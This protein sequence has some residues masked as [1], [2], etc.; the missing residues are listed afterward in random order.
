MTRRS[1]ITD[2]YAVLG[3]HEGSSAAE[4]KR[5]YR[6][7][8]LR[9]HPDRDPS[10]NA[11]EVF[12]NVH[13]AYRV[14]SDPAQRYLFERGRASSSENIRPGP[15]PSQRRRDHNAEQI[16]MEEP[17]RAIDP[18]LFKGLHITGLLFGLGCVGGVGTG[19]LFNDWPPLMLAFML[20]GLVVLP[21]CWAVLF[22]KEK[23]PMRR[24]FRW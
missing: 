2:P 3:V 5:A 22:S 18:W 24:G 6:E 10:P 9:C 15:A 11:A 12:R 20:P 23:S 16:P 19:Y 7:R 13:E 17:E 21:D 8:V 4:I 14:L 1:P